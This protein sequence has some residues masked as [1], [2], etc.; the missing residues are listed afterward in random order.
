MLN[1]VYEKRALFNTEKKEI[2][3]CD[4]H[5]GVERE[6]DSLGI[7]VLNQTEKMIDETLE[8][9]NETNARKLIILGDLKHGIGIDEK[10]VNDLKNFVNEVSKSVNIEIIKGNHD[11]KIEK[12][13]NIKVHGS[14]GFLNNDVYLLHGHTWPETS[15]GRARYLV[16]GHMHPEIKIRHDKNPKNFHAVWLYG[17]ATKK[18]KDKYNFQGNII[19]MPAFNPLVGMVIRNYP[20]GPLF[21]NGFV[22]LENMDVYLLD[23]TNIGK[24]RDFIQ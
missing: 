16:M 11:G 9:I 7:K 1:P 6:L 2:Y 8:I 19:V 21:K 15:I 4:L 20:I 22:N 5:I 12:I 23:S 14:R 3:I 18:F 17:K 10:Y 24:Y 13:L